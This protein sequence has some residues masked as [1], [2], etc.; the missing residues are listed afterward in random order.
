MV[1]ANMITDAF[2]VEFATTQSRKRATNPPYPVDAR[3]RRS[4]RQLPPT[5]RASARAVLRAM[6]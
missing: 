1:R 3:S 4:N 5:G 2:F 6:S